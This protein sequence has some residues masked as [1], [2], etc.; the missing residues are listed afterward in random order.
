M[1]RAISR[2]T[3]IR[4][5]IEKPGLTLEVFDQLEAAVVYGAPFIER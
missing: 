1:V 5:Q 2:L 3:G 4:L